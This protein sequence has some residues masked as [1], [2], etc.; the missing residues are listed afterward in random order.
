MSS[1]LCRFSVVHVDDERW[2]ETVLNCRQVELGYLNVRL[3]VFD[4]RT[5]D[6][7]AVGR[8]GF[9]WL[10]IEDAVG[11]VLCAAPPLV[12]DGIARP[13]VP[14]GIHIHRIFIFGQTAF[15]HIEIVELYCPAYMVADHL[16]RKGTEDGV[17]ECGLLHKFWKC[18][19]VVDL[20][21]VQLVVGD[22]VAA[23]I[24]GQ[25]IAQRL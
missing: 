13:F 6:G 11:I 19:G 21:L 7:H 14:V 5:P 1:F 25:A 2:V 10:E 4:G 3:Y 22:A 20:Q 18:H 12:F 8:T 9:R 17:V 15:L 16:Y 23:H 24:V